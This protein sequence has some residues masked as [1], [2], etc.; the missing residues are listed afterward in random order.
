MKKSKS[1]KLPAAEPVVS[2]LP[3]R[4]ENFSW[5]RAAAPHAHN[6]KDKCAHT[7]APSSILQDFPDLVDKALQPYPEALD[8][9]ARAVK[10]WYQR[11]DAAS[12]F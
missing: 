8:A 4:R 10:E 5:V 12:R 6:P 3:Q 7:G 2:Q 11:E 9:V 1:T